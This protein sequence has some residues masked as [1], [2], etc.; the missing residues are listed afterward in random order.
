MATVRSG[1]ATTM[2]LALTA[3]SGSNTRNRSALAVPTVGEPPTPCGSTFRCETTGPA[4]WL[5]PVWS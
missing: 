5:E 2:L 4:F 1:E 3:T